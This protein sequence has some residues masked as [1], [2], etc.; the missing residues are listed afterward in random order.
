MR[1]KKSVSQ[2]YATL[3]EQGHNNKV[4]CGSTQM[5]TTGGVQRALPNQQDQGA[6]CPESTGNWHL[7][8]PRVES[9]PAYAHA[10][11]H[12]GAPNFMATYQGVVPWHKR[13]S[14]KSRLK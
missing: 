5:Q 11:Y 4:H 1:K 6:W 7:Y 2:T 8:A 9:S 13:L 14:Q 3:I 12:G 10:H